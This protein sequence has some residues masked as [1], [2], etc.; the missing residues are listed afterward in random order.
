MFNFTKLCNMGILERAAARVR[1]AHLERQRT[2]RAYNNH[3]HGTKDVASLKDD[4]VVEALRLDMQL[5]KANDIAARQ[6]YEALK[7]CPPLE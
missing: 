6:T 4:G 7:A 5:A 1:T 2:Q 3:I